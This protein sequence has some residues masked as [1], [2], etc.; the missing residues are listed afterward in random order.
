MTSSDLFYLYERMKHDD[1]RKCNDIAIAGHN[2]I[3]DLLDELQSEGLELLAI[4]ISGEFSFLESANGRRYDP[5][6][7]LRKSIFCY[8]REKGWTRRKINRSFK[9]LSKLLAE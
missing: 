8:L 9:Q 6:R 4:A 2:Y 7:N 1:I 3:I 5:R